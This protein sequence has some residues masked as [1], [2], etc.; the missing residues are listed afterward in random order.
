MK[1]LFALLL[2]V[3]CFTTFASASE[4]KG[5]KFNPGEMITHHIGDD[6]TL[7]FADGMVLNLPVILYGENGLDVFSSGNFYNENHEVVP[8]KNYIMEHGHIY[9]ADEHGHPRT[10]K[11]EDGKEK[12]VGPLDFSITKNVASLF[13]SA[14]LL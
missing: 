13:I 7:H 10:V 9:Y 6:Y 5:G 12:H 8:Y 3:L 11:G 1:K 4:E 14:V 2:V